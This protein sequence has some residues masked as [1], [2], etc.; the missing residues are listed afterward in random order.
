MATIAP[1]LQVHIEQPGTDDVLECIVQTDNR[2]AI[3][4]DIT[5]NRKNWPATADAPMLWASFMAWHAMRRTGAEELR[6]LDLDGFLGVCIEVRPIR[7]STGEAVPMSEA[8]P[9][10]YSPTPSEP[11][12]LAG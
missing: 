2:D 7:E 10:D 1:R 3:Q 11:A 8:K 5:R 4:W 9:E 12:A 6:G